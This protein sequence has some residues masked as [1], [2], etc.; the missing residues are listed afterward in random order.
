VEVRERSGIF[1]APQ[2]HVGG[3]LLE[4]AA[5]WAARVMVEGWRRGIAFPDV[6]A[7]FRRCVTGRTVRCAFV[8]ATEDVLTAFGHDLAEQLGLQTQRVRLDALPRFDGRTGSWNGRIP[9]VL[10]QADLVVTT[11]FHAWRVGPLASALEKPM[12]AA[13][14][15]AD[16]VAAVERQLRNGALT[17]ICADPGFGERMRIQYQ[18]AITA[19]TRFRVIQADDLRSIAALDRA[20]PV[21]LTRAA[22]QRLGKLK[23]PLV[24]PNAPTISASSALE[25]AEFL[26]R[27]NLEGA[28]KPGAGLA[29]TGSP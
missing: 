4:E 20:E 7:F 12:I 25:I 21:L 2:A 15:N 6:P 28:P 16:L 14:V 9:S 23:L 17:V 10:Q 11:A 8:E 13:T 1:A 24:F 5:Q 18:D 26:I 22:R 29:R 19:D 27:F 3:V